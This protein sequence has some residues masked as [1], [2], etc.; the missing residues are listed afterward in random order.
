MAKP[1]KSR[2]APKARPKSSGARGKQ[3]VVPPDVINQPVTLSAKAVA[4]RYGSAQDKAPAASAKGSKKA[5]KGTTITI[6]VGGKSATMTPEQ[7]K[8]GLAEL[9]ARDAAAD[10]DQGEPIPHAESGGPVPER[11]TV[12]ALVGT[13]REKLRQTVARI[14]RLEEERKDLAGDIREVY[15]EAKSLGFDTKVLRKVISLRKVEK[16]ERDEQEMILETYLFALGE[17]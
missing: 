1:P 3:A 17:I 10:D 13:S 12:G 6:S 2:L 8:V 14:E 16:A 15:A 4:R 5:S 11:N 7:L 9:K